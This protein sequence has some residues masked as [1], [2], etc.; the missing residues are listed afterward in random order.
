MSEEMI[1]AITELKEEEAVALA[2]RQLDEEV[3]PGEILSQCQAGMTHVGEL[4]EKKEYYLSELIYSGAIF[5][6]IS[7]LLEEAAQRR[8]ETGSRAIKGRVILGTIQGDVHD[9]GKNIVTMLL[10]NSGYEVIDLGIDVPPDAF[11]NK[12]QETGVRVVGISALLTTSFSGMKKVVDLLK[13]AGLRP[14]T[15]VMI[16]GGVVDEKARQFVGADLQST[17][18]YEAVLF[19]DKH[20]EPSAG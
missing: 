1:T 11:V 20:C 4:F 6:R 14:E 12:A 13:E 9:L 7:V 17:N 16:G 3:D 19:C 18:A 2:S 15:K 8:G 10:K 5:K